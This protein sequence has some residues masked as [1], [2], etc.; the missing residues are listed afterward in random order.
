MTLIPPLWRTFFTP[1][2]LDTIDTVLHQEHVTHGDTLSIFPPR[3]HIF[4]ALQLV[5]HP[6]NVRVVILGQDPYIRPGQAT[7]LAFGVPKED[8]TRVLPP[9]LRNIMRRLSITDTNP[10]T[11]SFDVSL[12]SWAAQGVLLLNTALTVREG[13]SNSHAQMW[14]PV[15]DD[16]L[17][18][19]ASYRHETADLPPLVF[20]LW[21]GQAIRKGDHIGLPNMRHRRVCRSHPSPLSCWRGVGG[22]EPFMG[23]VKGGDLTEED[24]G[25]FGEVNEIEWVCSSGC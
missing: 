12:E 14:K 22:F 20:M 15:T 10:T 2:L 21:G 7:G 16:F 11:T 8:R 19:F 18:R 5:G 25:C 6:D 23:M 1:V 9:S 13:A 17:H 24:T 3:D 4:R